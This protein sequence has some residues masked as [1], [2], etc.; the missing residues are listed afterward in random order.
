MTNT[1]N[2]NQVSNRQSTRTTALFGM[3]AAVFFV[4]VFT[5]EGWLR[6]SYHPLSMFVSELSL[7]S[8]GWVQIVNFLVTGVLIF[9]FGRGIKKYFQTGAAAKAG[10]LL[11]Q[12]I[13][14]SLMASAFFPTDPSAMFNQHS[15][16]GII[17][18][19]FGAIVFL[20]MPIVCFIFFRRFRSDTEWKALAWWTLGVGI[21]MVVGIGFLKVSQFPE[22]NLFLWKGL[23][24]RI[25]LMT[26]MAWVFSFATKLLKQT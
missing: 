14:L 24:Q 26:F 19:I 6:P 5:I 11:L 20:C 18:G 4:A 9:L 15:F 2:I 22:S 10:P 1:S 21:I 17:H 13:G 25:I 16:H 8:R 12:I 23:I 7:G 3:S